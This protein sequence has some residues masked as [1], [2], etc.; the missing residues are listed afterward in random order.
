MNEKSKTDAK[1]TVKSDVPS[2]AK[3]ETPATPDADP[4]GPAP[5]VAPVNEKSKT[6]AK[7]EVPAPD[8]PETPS[9]PEKPEPGTNPSPTVES[10]PEIGPMAGPEPKPDLKPDAKPEPKPEVNPDVK[11]DSKPAV[12]PVAGVGPLQAPSFPAADLDASLKGVIGRDTSTPSRMP[13]G[14]SSRKS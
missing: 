10:K 3:P 7:P 8:K 13:I 11:P 9:K 12:K 5:A 6:D 2:P 1:P 4:F 14:A